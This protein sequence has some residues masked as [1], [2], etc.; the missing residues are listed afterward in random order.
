MRLE[1]GVPNAGT[2][3]IIDVDADPTEEQVAGLVA[4]GLVVLKAAGE[5]WRDWALEHET[6]DDRETRLL[7]EKNRMLNRQAIERQNFELEEMLA[8]TT[9]GIGKHGRGS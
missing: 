5:A 8:G 3:V 7:M 1:L 6:D 4:D 2:K 9:E